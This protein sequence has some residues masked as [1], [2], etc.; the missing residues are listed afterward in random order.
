MQGFYPWV[1]KIPWSRKW[2]PSPVFLTG[3]SHRGAWWATVYGVAKHQTW[4]SGSPCMYTCIDE[5]NLVPGVSK[6]GKYITSPDWKVYHLSL[7]YFLFKIRSHSSG[8]LESQ[9]GR[10]LTMDHWEKWWKTQK[11]L[12]LESR[13]KDTH[14]MWKMLL[15]LSKQALWETKWNVYDLN[16]KS[17]YLAQP[18]TQI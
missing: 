17:M 9:Q 8:R 4:L 2:Q 6:L 13:D 18:M 1:G 14:R 10:C 5:E 15:V 3:K 16:N 12:V 7:L 11:N